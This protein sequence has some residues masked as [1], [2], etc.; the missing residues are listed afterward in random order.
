MRPIVVVCTFYQ[1]LTDSLIKYKCFLI[2]LLIWITMILEFSDLNERWSIDRNC[3]QSTLALIT[4][5]MRYDNMHNCTFFKSKWFSFF[6]MFDQLPSTQ[7]LN[8]K[9]R[10]FEITFR[11]KYQLL[12][13]HFVRD[14]K[15]PMGFLQMH[16]LLSQHFSCK[17]NAIELQYFHCIADD[18]LVKRDFFIEFFRFFFLVFSKRKLLTSLEMCLFYSSNV[19][20]V[21]KRKMNK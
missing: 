6:Q 16:F 2:H 18:K 11:Q 4:C 14:T 21:Y 8:A 12:S 17:A 13:W 7:I 9:M 20:S 19:Y 3:M 10:L 1:R 5:Y 15:I